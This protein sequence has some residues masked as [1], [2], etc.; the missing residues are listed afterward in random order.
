MPT[1]HDKQLTRL[2]KKDKLMLEKTPLPIVTV[3]GA[4]PEDLKR[5]YGLKNDQ[6]SNDIIYSRAHFSMA[7]GVLRYLWQSDMPKASKAWLTDPTNFVTA[8]DWGKIS[9]TEKIGEIIARHPTLQIVKSLI[10]QFGRK[11]LPILDS[12]TPPLMYLFEK[13]DQ[14]IL[15]FHIAAGNV[16][17][18]MG[19]RVIQVVTDPHVRDEYVEAANSS[20]ISYCVFD[21]RTKLD[22]LERANI[23]DVKLTADRIEVTGPPIDL[24]IIALRKNKKSQPPK[25][26]RL[27]ITT[28]GLGTNKPEI[29][30]LLE[31]LLPVLKRKDSPVE[32]RLYAGTEKD[33]VAMA[34]RVAEKTGVR[35]NIIN[36]LNKIPSRL[37]PHTRQTERNDKSDWKS[38]SLS[39]ANQPTNQLTI[40]SHPQIFDANE[41]LIKYGLSWADGVMTKPSGDMAYDA[42]GA[43]C[44]LLTLKPWGVWE[45]RIAQIFEEKEL[46]RPAE[47]DHILEQLETLTQR[48]DNQPSW[49]EQSLDNVKHIDKTYLH[50]VERIVEA[51]R[52]TG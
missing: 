23:L 28:G 12:I 2:F 38:V 51:V 48:I 9:S 3:V 32:V 26:L 16:L 35:I 36:N 18:Q 5:W 15:S 4:F 10:D 31:Q 27:L 52:K 39:S 20:T 34:K 19:K 14:P 30:S 47:T 42:V 41:L 21:E 33:F 45:E 1:L 8:K 6:V 24:R 7:Y 50:G 49:I 43:G 25:P 40:I 46:S 44:F 37:A 29:E 17:A 11:K 22:M 13:V